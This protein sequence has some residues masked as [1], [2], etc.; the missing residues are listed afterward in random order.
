MTEGQSRAG[1]GNLGGDPSISRDGPGQAARILA[2]PQKELPP[3]NPCACLTRRQPWRPW[4]PPGLQLG[5]REGPTHVGHAQLGMSLSCDRSTQTARIPQTPEA[6]VRPEASCPGAK[7]LSTP[8]GGTEGQSPMLG[9][10]F[11]MKHL[12]LLSLMFPPRF[13]NHCGW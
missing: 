1:L 4:L 6:S 3:T 12:F 2:A 5:L 10:I 11:D 8:G 7:T 13:K 9:V